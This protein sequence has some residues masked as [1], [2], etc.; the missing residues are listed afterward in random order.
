MTAFWTGTS[1]LPPINREARIAILGVSTEKAVKWREVDSKPERIS[2]KA[3]HPPHKPGR[4]IVRFGMFGSSDDSRIICIV[5]VTHVEEVDCR[6]GVSAEELGRPLY[7][8]M[9][10]SGVTIRDLSGKISFV[11]GLRLA[12]RPFI[13]AAG[14]SIGRHS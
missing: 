10:C 9:E 11:A 14:H 7:Q 1:L 6:A 5:V 12:G 8:Y 2:A 3:K 13:A 4:T